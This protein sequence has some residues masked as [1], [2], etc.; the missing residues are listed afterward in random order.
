MLCLTLKALGLLCMLH[1]YAIPWRWS[2][3]SIRS[4]AWED[5]IGWCHSMQRWRCHIRVKDIPLECFFILRWEAQLRH[6]QWITESWHHKGW[7]R[8][9]VPSSPTT[10]LPP[11]LPTDHI[12]QCHICPFL[13]HLHRW[14]PPPRWA[15]CSS[16]RYTYLLALPASI[17]QQPRSTPFMFL[18]STIN[19]GN[20]LNRAKR[21]FTPKW[22]ITK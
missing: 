21:C 10:D 14:W 18:P 1:I 13:E 9:L 7:K 12:S 5:D 4:L 3:K 20:M 17:S 2:H 19:H 16:M 22:R 6:I 15:A 11:I 8:P